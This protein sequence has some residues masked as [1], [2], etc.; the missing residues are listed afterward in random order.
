M[1]VAHGGR[2][3]RLGAP[4]PRVRSSRACTDNPDRHLTA[5]HACTSRHWAAA[6]G[7]CEVV[8]G[9]SDLDRLLDALVAMSE[10]R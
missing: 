9:E 2:V 4:T 1:S 6:R 7:A 8:G 3:V 10:S 5:I